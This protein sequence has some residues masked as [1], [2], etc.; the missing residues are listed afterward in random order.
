[1]W[2]VAST[3][4]GESLIVVL[5]LSSVP[6]VRLLQVVAVLR[7][8]LTRQVGDGQLG[9]VSLLSSGRLVVVPGHGSAQ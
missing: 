9:Q 7:A 5:A 4:G 2:A 6:T 3:V 8:V 1:M